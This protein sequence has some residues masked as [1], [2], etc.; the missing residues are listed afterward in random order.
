MLM[1]CMLARRETDLNYGGAGDIANNLS[2]D[3]MG[4]LQNVFDTVIIGLVSRV[5]RRLLGSVLPSFS[6]FSHFSLD[7][8]PSEPARFVSSLC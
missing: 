7:I 1:R 8:H 2:L 5:A 4:G 3:R 6:F